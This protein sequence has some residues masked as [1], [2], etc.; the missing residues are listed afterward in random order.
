VVGPPSS[1]RHKGDRS[2]AILVCW[3]TWHDRNAN[4]F[5]ANEKPMHDLIAEVKDEAGLWSSEGAMGIT[6]LV[7]GLVSE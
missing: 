7:E 5:K 3:L 1:V 2:I 4:F 6:S